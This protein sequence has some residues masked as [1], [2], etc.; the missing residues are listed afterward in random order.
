MVFSPDERKMFERD[1]SVRGGRR[2]EARLGAFARA[3]PDARDQTS[4]A[5]FSSAVTRAFDRVEDRHS[6]VLDGPAR[7][8]DGGVASALSAGR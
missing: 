4:D 2:K 8:V 6:G 3:R 5:A 1:D 7:V